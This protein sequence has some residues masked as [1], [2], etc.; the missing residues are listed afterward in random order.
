MCLGIPGQIVAI[1]DNDNS[2]AM[3]DVSGVQREVNIL[4]V[5]EE[6]KKPQDYVGAWVLVHVGFAMSHLD[7]AEAQRTL[8]LLAQL[9]EFQEGLGELQEELDVKQSEG[10]SQ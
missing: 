6:G 4:C 1:S 10:D 8:Q 5:M 9:G 2:M 7:E 3:V